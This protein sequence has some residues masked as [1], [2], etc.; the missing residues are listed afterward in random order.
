V[1]REAAG[2]FDEGMVTG[3]EQGKKLLKSMFLLWQYSVT[4]Y[5]FNPARF[6]FGITDHIRPYG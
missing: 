6:D 3:L 1:L 5:A 2:R 4:S